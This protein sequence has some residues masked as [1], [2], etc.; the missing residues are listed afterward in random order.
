MEEEEV[1]DDAQADDLR[2]GA[3]AA[4]QGAEGGEGDEGG[5][6]GRAEGEGQGEELGP[7]EN[8]ESGGGVLIRGVQFVV[9]GRKTGR[10]EGGLLLEG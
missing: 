10:G 7:E 3:E 6:V 1:V 4:L 9:T 2:R 8:G 5:G